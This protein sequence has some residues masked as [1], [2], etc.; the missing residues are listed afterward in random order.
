MVGCL[1]NEDLERS[2]CGPI[3]Y[4]PSICQQELRKPMKAPS[5]GGVLSEI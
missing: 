5:Q 4:F 3:E 2:I 1:I